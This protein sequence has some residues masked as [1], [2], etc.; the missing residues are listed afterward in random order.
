MLD[1][2][3]AHHA[4]STWRDFFI[5]IAT[6][7]IGLL[8]AVALEQSVEA[9]HHRHQRHQLEADL[10]AEGL[11]NINIALQNM[12]VSERRRNLD[13]QQFAEFLLAARQHRSPSYLALTR[14]SWA[15]RYVK[16]AYAVWTVAQQSG[17]LNLLPRADAQRYVRVY[18]LVQIAVD[19]LE[20]SNAAMQKT[21]SALLPAV[22]DTSSP[23]T[24]VAQ[25]N[26]RRFDLS[27]LNPA[28]LQQLRTVVGDDMTITEQ[29][30]NMN[31]FLYGIEWAVLHGSTSDEENLRTIYDAQAIYWRGG[32][33]AL[34]AKYPPPAE[35]SPLPAVTTDTNP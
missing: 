22:A 5:H 20:L 6:I 27:L 23:Q 7:V 11:R 10:H 15:Y 16:P 3:P 29:N 28:E 8:I 14:Y 24:F 33:Q 18:S 35:A 13:A 30:I 1:V 4:A 31:A 32:S 17:T 19:R 26:Q 12:E 34:L 25:F 9:L 2:H 21:M